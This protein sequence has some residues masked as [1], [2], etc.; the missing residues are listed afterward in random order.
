MCDIADA[1]KVECK[2]HEGIQGALGCL[3]SEIVGLNRVVDEIKGTDPKEKEEPDRKVLLLGPFLAEGRG[4]IE[5]YAKRV[6]CAV[7]EL[8][9]L[10]F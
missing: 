10:L 7:E 8:R 6:G 2:K 1:K 4:I 3:E 9:K 5:E